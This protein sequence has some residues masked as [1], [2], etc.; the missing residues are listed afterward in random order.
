MREGLV[1]KYSLAISDSTV[2]CSSS[3]RHHRNMALCPKHRYSQDR[4]ASWKVQ[5]L[6]TK[7]ELLRS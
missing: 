1:G 7:S 3:P 2:S 5:A 6:V 4:R